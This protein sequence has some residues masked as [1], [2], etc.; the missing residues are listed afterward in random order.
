MKKIL[1]VFLPLAIMMLTVA[2]AQAAGKML[3][4]AH[5]DY[6]GTAQYRAWEDAK[7]F[8][9]ENSN[10]KYILD[11][12]DS[13]KLGPTQTTM[14]GAQFGTVHMVEDG[15]PNFASFD[16][17][18]GIFDLPFLFPDY[19]SIDIILNGPI[20]QKILDH[21]SQKS[22]TKAMAFLGNGYR[23]ILT[24]KAL[25]H[26]SEANGMKIRSTPSKAHMGGLNAMGF[27]A[28]PMPWTETITGVQQR[29]IDGF[30][31]D[32][33]QAM[34]M[35]LGE[36]APY[37]LVTEH[38]YTPHLAVAN[39]EWW[40]SLNAEDKA[41][42]EKMFKLLVENSTKYAREDDIKA[43]TALVE[44]GHKLTTLDPKERAQWMEK[45]KNAY[46]DNPQ[47]PAE[48]VEE[49]RAELKKMGKIK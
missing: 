39:Q 25:A 42:F 27:S 47:I 11:L 7:K 23:G 45:T 46:K 38:I 17:A 22:G 10:G 48:W 44:K 21:M 2:G 41:L 4:V 5:A 37:V 19:E 35:G 16:P 14:Q 24:N 34:N 6:P 33:A 18:I 29:V 32:L 26:P 30:D 8:I 1:F 13:Y 28:T 49:I 12:N 31:L 3:K 20:G 15:S 36:I 40:D 9:E 43:R